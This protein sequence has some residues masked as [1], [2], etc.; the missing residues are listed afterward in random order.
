MPDLS[1]TIETV[2]AGPAEV[3]SDG[4]SVTS[5]SLPDLIEADRYLKQQSALGS[6]GSAWN[7]LR[8]ARVVPPGAVGP[9]SSEG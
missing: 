2:A 6:A 9:C 4:T 7:C 5:Q 3:V 1:E 8:P